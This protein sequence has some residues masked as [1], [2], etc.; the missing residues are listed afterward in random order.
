MRPTCSA[1]SIV[2]RRRVGS[3]SRPRAA[4]AGRRH[5]PAAA[6]FLPDG[7]H[8]LF[9]QGKGTGAKGELW[10]A[11][12][13]LE[14]RQVFDRA[15]NVT[16]ADGSCSA[17]W[18][19][20]CWRSGSIPASSVERGGVALAPGLESWPFRFLGNYSYS[21]GRLVYREAVLPEARIEWFDPGSGARTALLERGAYSAM[22]LWPDGRRLLVGRPEGRG[23]RENTWFYDPVEGGWSRL[24]RKAEVE[25]HFAWLP[26]GRQV[27][28]QPESG[29]SAQFVSLDG[30]EVE[31]ARRAPA[32][33]RSWIGRLVGVRHRSA[34]GSRKPALI[35]F[36]G[37]ECGTVCPS[38][39]S[40]PRRPTNGVR[41]SRP[42]AAMW[43]TSRTRVAARRS[44]W[45]GARA[46]PARCKSRL[47]GPTRVA[48]HL[49]GAGRGGR[50]ISW[51]R[52]R[53]AL[54]SGGHLA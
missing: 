5:Q 54:G 27:V 18:T 53:A 3:R 42:M 20:C 8:F 51:T 22:R 6:S 32:I 35:S 30:G 43:R 14:S 25:Y 7:K 33:P 29:V 13:C 41:E 10:G 2:S 34:T 24:S 9:V 49:P 39:C 15:S 16:F 21:A 26:D 44:T 28:L 45:P 12:G 36:D 1:R 47:R 46:R 40:R 17:S 37:V 52:G 11:S 50:C 4:S 48:V 38:R 31:T 19:R 23:S